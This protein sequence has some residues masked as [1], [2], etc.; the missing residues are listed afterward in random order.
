MKSI[1]RKKSRLRKR[2]DVGGILP[3][4]GETFAQDAV[5]EGEVEVDP[6]VDLNGDGE[7]SDG[8]K[9]KYENKKKGKSALSGAAS[10][11]LTGASFG[12]WGAAIGGVIGGIGGWMKGKDGMKIKKKRF[13]LLKK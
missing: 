12:P 11:A 8:E 5:N 3:T 2:Y 10:G 6:E 1:K 4:G 9:K 7:I 13:K